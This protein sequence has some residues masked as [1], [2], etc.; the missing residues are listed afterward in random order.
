MNWLSSLQVTEA[1]EETVP[2]VEPLYFEIDS[3]QVRRSTNPH[4]TNIGNPRSV[5]SNT[6]LA[7]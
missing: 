1:G 5:S 6:H 4:E 2:V 7:R 3:C